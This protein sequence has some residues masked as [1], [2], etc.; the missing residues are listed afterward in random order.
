MSYNGHEAPGQPLSD[1]FDALQQDL[2]ALA[3]SDLDGS[4]ENEDC[5]SDCCVF[6]GDLSR[7]A[8]EEILTEVFS[9][10]GDVIEVDVK[11][12]PVTHNNLGYGFVQFKSRAEAATAKQQLDG[13]EVAGRTIRC[14]WAQKNT[15]L[16][17]GD[18]DPTVDNQKLVQIFSPFGPIVSHETY[19]YQ[20][21]YGFVCFRY[22]SDAEKARSQMDGKV[23][24]SR[25]LRV[26]WADSN[27]KRNCVYVQF[28][29]AQLTL[30][31]FNERV[32]MHAFQPYGTL[33][34]VHLP[35]HPDG[36][37]KGM[38]FCHFADDA[39]GADSASR[40]IQ[41]LNGACLNLSP[42]VPAL[43]LDCRLGKSKNS[44][45]RRTA[46]T[47]QLQRQLQYQRHL[48]FQRAT[49]LLSAAALNPTASAPAAAPAAPL[50]APTTSSSP[51][52]STLS[53]AHTTSPVALPAN[54]LSSPLN[55]NFHSPSFP[56]P[57]PHHPAAAAGGGRR[58]PTASSSSSSFPSGYPASPLA[59]T[60]SPALLARAPADNFSNRNP[61]L[62]AP[63][64]SD[65]GVPNHHRPATVPTGRSPSHY[66][67]SQT[68]SGPRMPQN[69]GGPFPGS[70][71]SPVNWLGVSG[72]SPHNVAPP[73]WNNNNNHNNHNNTGVAHNKNRN[74]MAH[75]GGQ[76]P[77]TPPRFQN[78]SNQHRQQNGA[79]ST[80]SNSTA[81]AASSSSSASVSS[82][83][84]T[85]SASTAASSVSVASS[86]S[87]SSASVMPASSSSTSSSSSSASTSSSTSTSSSSTS[88]SFS[89]S[90]YSNSNAPSTPPPNPV[91]TLPMAVMT[92]NPYLSTSY[93]HPSSSLSLGYTAPPA[94][95]NG[96]MSSPSL[97]YN[98]YP[99]NS[100]YAGG[101]SQPLTPPASSHSPPSTP[102]P[103]VRD[104]NVATSVM[105]MYV[106]QSVQPVQSMSNLTPVGTMQPA[107]P[108]FS[109]NYYQSA[110]QTT[111]NSYANYGYTYSGSPGREKK[112][113]T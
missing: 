54:P 21:K 46:Q 105:P 2:A 74:N 23:V 65:S 109:Q 50:P 20:G 97:A 36:T 53:A 76:H 94:H 66:G 27:P 8:T 38:A 85:A 79:A 111:G 95:F 91:P 6:V 55:S 33:D 108:V 92:S 7:S 39:Q 14:G 86:S 17:V 3:I 9:K 87:S 72:N 101:Y 41:A 88:R 29:P 10:Y 106:Y 19:A 103:A 25:V 89:S 104:A 4:K 113:R 26:G 71:A 24:G 44:T 52:F 100:T 62:Q 67:V 15:T 107:S 5:Y 80:N 48:A 84:S 99:L 43:R 98:M 61:P 112:Y 35:R 57:N 68:Q 78:R 28:N 49:S 96:Y 56:N 31:E 51:S 16:F 18:L 70:V 42:S 1:A 75:H 110:P 37:L 77:Q 69:L 40:A 30:A 58:P 102:A 81:S 47:H 34:K 64:H 59:N 13:V 90:S 60:S 45:A 12:D 32:L 93:Y 22:R 73:R 82:S 83:A 11:R 63:H